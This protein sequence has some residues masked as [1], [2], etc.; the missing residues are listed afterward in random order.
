MVNYANVA[1]SMKEITKKV[2]LLSIV[3]GVTI[4][5][6]TLRRAVA[7]IWIALPTVIAIA[8]SETTIGL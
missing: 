5:M 3:K 7:P 2:I 1:E 6:K 4:I 8:P